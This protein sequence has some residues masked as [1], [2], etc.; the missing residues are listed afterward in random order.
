MVGGGGGMMA[1]MFE[2]EISHGKSWPQYNTT[3]Q[4]TYNIYISI[5]S[6]ILQLIWKL[7]PWAGLNRIEIMKL[8]SYL[9]SLI[10]Q[11]I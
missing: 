10:L 6:Q 5:T 3:I 4:N 7:M 2:L 1:I 8:F 11:N 9:V